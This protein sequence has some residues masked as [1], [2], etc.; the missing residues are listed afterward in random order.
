MYQLHP[1][2]VLRALFSDRP[3]QGAPPS[4][5]TFLF[6]GLDANYA[7]DIE[8]SASFQ[9][10]LEYHHDGV[11]FWTRHGV[12]HP[13][14]L[15]DYRGDGRRYHLNFSRIGFA[16]RHAAMV[17]F[18][19]LL[20]LPTDGRSLL[21][22]TD[23][24]AAHL[25]MIES[26]VLRGR[27]RHIF[28]SAEAVRLLRASGRFGWLAQRPLAAGPL[29]VLYRDSGRTVY[30]HLHFSNY[31]K[32]QQQMN[33]EAAAIAALLP[34]AVA[35]ARLSTTAEPVHVPPSARTERARSPGVQVTEPAL[36]IR[37]SSLYREGITPQALYEASRGVWRIGERREFAELVL[38]VAG[39]IVREVYAVQAWHPAG[40]TP[41]LTRS[42][43][44]VAVP[45]RRE[46]TG[47]PA[48]ES[49][50]RKYVGQSVA[51]YFPRGAANPVMYVN[52][53]VAG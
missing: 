32:F 34:D 46:F 30:L 2:E 44:D 52:I 6:I 29:P 45:G 13:F 27:A 37:V 12:H 39:G 4:E 49:V 11:A 40:S 41:Y 1:S 15:L 24:D 22:S 42:V 3:F 10:V 8:R 7:A 48:P 51:H 16:P 53:E 5:A 47:V 20:H 33:E 50:R 35:A 25:Q 31:G 38:A 26:A 36:L 18:V 17:S 21:E 43:A 19:E 23:L 14:L 9:Q 28:V